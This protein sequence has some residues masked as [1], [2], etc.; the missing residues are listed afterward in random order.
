MWKLPR[1]GRACVRVTAQAESAGQRA[2]PLSI[3]PTLPWSALCCWGRSKP[4]SSCA[5][6][7]HA[8]GP[9]GRRQQ[10][11]LRSSVSLTLSC[12]PGS[13]HTRQHELLVPHQKTSP[14]PLPEESGLSEPRG[15]RLKSLGPPL[16]HPGQQSESGLTAD[17]AGN[18]RSAPGRGGLLPN[19]VGFFV[20]TGNG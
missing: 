17:G 8:R 3:K 12:C 9:A 16:L 4:R 7:G 19:N 11:G 15:P 10:R 18:C 1:V 5:S 13:G 14:A 20:L 6:R 2:F